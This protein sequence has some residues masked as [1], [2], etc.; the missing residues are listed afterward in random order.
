MTC[1]RSAC[2]PAPMLTH[3][4]AAVFST[5]QTGLLNPCVC[6]PPLPP[7]LWVFWRY[8]HIFNYQRKY[9]SGGLFFPFVANRLLICLAV[10]RRRCLCLCLHQPMAG[11]LSACACRALPALAF[12]ETACRPER[13][14][15]SRFPLS[16][17]S[18]PATPP[19]RSW[20]RSQVSDC[21][22][23]GHDCGSGSRRTLSCAPPAALPQRARS[24]PPPPHTPTPA[25]THS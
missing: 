3:A 11:C 13:G 24:A 7:G 18:T 25:P 17:S 14:A 6:T 5:C 23:Q 10:R 9:E 21:S 19:P 12:F 16:P 8:Q 15:H 2:A 4:C 1:V 22:Q 20:W